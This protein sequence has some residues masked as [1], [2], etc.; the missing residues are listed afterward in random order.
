MK[1]R[2]IS[3]FF[4]IYAMRVRLKSHQ[5]H[6]FLVFARRDYGVRHCVYNLVKEQ[7]GFNCLRSS[8]VTRSF[9]DL[10]NMRQ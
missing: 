7:S 4:H 10:V 6:T 3:R 1:L 8:L 2:S 9:L 5:I